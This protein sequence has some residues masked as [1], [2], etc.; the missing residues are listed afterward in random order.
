MQRYKVEIT[1]AA[2]ADIQEIFDYIARDSRAAA[3][4]LTEEIEHQIETLERFPLRCPV[5]P[6]SQ[7]LGEKYRHLI[8]GNYRTI[9]KI[10]ESIV[11][12]MRVIHGARLLDMGIL[13]K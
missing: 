10:E 5:I 2:E 7:E 1:R 4:R 11:I 3:L 6:E 9:F 12:I 8:Y 13:E